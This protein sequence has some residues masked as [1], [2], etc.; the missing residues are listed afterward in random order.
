MAQIHGC[1]LALVLLCVNV[2][3]RE[4]RYLNNV[5]QNAE[6]ETEAEDP[7]KALL[8]IQSGHIN[9]DLKSG[10]SFSNN[11]DVCTRFF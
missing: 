10:F 8:Q 11:T 7:N 3:A 5:N 2:N 6:D 9:L 1:I 4:L